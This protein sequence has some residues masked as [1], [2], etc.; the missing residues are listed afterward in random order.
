MANTWVPDIG[1]EIIHRDDAR[2]GR[3]RAINPADNPV[4]EVLVDWADGKHTWIWIG[5]IEPYQP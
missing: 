4:F 2:V 1:D 3:I 5:A